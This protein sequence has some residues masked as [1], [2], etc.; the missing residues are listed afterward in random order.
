MGA[1]GGKV[2]GSPW[3]IETI[4]IDTNDSEEDPLGRC[5]CL[6][7]RRTSRLRNVCTCS[8]D[9]KKPS[10]NNTI[11]HLSASLANKEQGL[12]EKRQKA[13][14][15]RASTNAPQN[16]PL[17]GRGSHANK[18]YQLYKTE[19]CRSHTEIGYC[20]YGDK[21][22]F[23]HSK[24]ELRY[25]QRHPKYKTETCKTFW[26]EGSC[27]YGKRCCFIHIPNT[28]IANLPIHGRQRDSGKNCT[29][30]TL[31]I[32]IDEH[33]HDELIY[34]KIEQHMP[35]VEGN[36]L[37]CLGKDREDTDEIWISGVSQD[38]SCRGHGLNHSHSESIKQPFEPIIEDESSEGIM[39]RRPFW[40]SS[41]SKIW[42]D[43][44]TSLFYLDGPCRRRAKGGAFAPGGAVCKSF[45]KKISDFVFG[46][47]GM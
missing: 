6:L 46:N 44:E 5:R 3:L 17:S 22:Q 1:F 41:Y 28:D 20:R 18:K 45:D 23:A 31:G 29:G 25:V 30:Y 33:P 35:L 16:Y 7:S 21:C 24:A 2:D 12:F 4:S 13:H 26:E 42:M 14:D 27:P 43:E 15:S 19:M 39:L 8:K 40:E 34:T 38:P 10:Q 9:G 11:S 47:L 32:E 37:D 36:P